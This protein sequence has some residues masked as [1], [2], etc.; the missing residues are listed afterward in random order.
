MLALRL[1]PEVEERLTE[2]ARKTGRTKSYYAKK[3]I[4]EYLEE[5]EDY[6]LGEA[7]Y[8]EFIA[9]DQKTYT[10]DEASNLL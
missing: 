6:Y 9:G 10:I 4:I 5:L 8:Q 2:L 7:A 1:P 3:A